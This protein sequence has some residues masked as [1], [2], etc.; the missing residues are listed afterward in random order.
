MV[1][2]EPPSISPTESF[3]I[4][5]RVS[6]SDR[7]VWDFMPHT[8]TRPSIVQTKSWFE[9]EPEPALL[10][11]DD[12]EFK[13]LS[14]TIDPRRRALSCK[15]TNHGSYLFLSSSPIYCHCR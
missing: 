7:T 4:N 14:K 6:S 10:N 2:F 15:Q 5:S 12:D 1:T 13:E 9:Q 11:D 3:I 8:W